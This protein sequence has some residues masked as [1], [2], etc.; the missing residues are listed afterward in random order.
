MKKYV[1]LNIENGKFPN[2]WDEETHNRC[3]NNP[4]EL[5]EHRKTNPTWKLISYECITDS[6]FEFNKFMKIK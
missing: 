2:S 3:F 1:W 6:N 5:I 4:N